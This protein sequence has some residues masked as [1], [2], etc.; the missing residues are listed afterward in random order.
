MCLLCLGNGKEAIVTEMEGGRVG[1][2]RA[3]GSED[4]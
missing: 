4:R 2:R 1:G 3:G